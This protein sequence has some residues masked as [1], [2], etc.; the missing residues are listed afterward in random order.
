MNYAEINKVDIANGPGCRV[1]VFVQGCDFHCK[2]CFNQNAWD[3]NGGVVF[4]DNTIQKILS[5]CRYEYINGLSILGGE[6]LHPKNIDGILQL[7]KAFK[8]RFPDKNIWLWTGF[9]YEDIT[10]KEIFNYIDVLVDGQ[11]V[12]ELRD[13]TLKFRGS[14]NQRI[15]NIPETIKQNKIILLDE[16]M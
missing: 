8:E 4:N 13:L 6:P 11:Y 10:R 1:S 3:F 16:N 15:I 14:S 7:M 5:L 2:N 12:D 9:K